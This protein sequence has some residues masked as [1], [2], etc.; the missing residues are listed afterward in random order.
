MV[1]GCLACYTVEHQLGSAGRRKLYLKVIRSRCL[2]DVTAGVSLSYP[3]I[4]SGT[5]VVY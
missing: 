5:V 1:G 4:P 3:D 2:S